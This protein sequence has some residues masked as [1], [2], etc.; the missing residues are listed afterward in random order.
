VS[1][2]TNDVAHTL[3]GSVDVLENSMEGDGGSADEVVYVRTVSGDF[4]CA[5][6]ATY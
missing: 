2:V 5:A 4:G 3:L 1:G 6:G